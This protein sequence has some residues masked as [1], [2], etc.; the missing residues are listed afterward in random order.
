MRGSRAFIKRG[1]L[2]HEQGVA[3][4][5]TAASKKHG[6]DAKA[7]KAVGRVAARAGVGGGRGSQPTTPT[8]WRQTEGKGRGGAGGGVLSAGGGRGGC[9]EVPAPLKNLSQNCIP[10]PHAYCRNHGFPLARAGLLT[11]VYSGRVAVPRS[12]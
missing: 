7:G 3:E 2:T 4:Y 10:L 11:V 9:A 5:D 6:A 8:R 12:V 1:F